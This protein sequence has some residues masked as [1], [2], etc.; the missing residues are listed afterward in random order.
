DSARVTIPPVTISYT[1]WNNS[2]KKNI[3]TN[4]ITVTVRTLPVNRQEDIRDVKEPVKLPLN[5]LLI[6]LI[7]LALFIIGIASYYLYT[8]YRKKKELKSAIIPEIIIPPH[9]RALSE[10]SELEKKK[11]WQN[12]FVKEYHSEVTEIVRQYFEGRFNFRALEMTSSEILAVLSYLEDGKKI[13]E[14]LEL[15]FSN[16]DLVKFAKYEPMPKV[17]EEMMQQA[18]EIVNDTIPAVNNSTESGES[19]VQ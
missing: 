3:R 8:Y 17:N 5:W 16:A 18:F 9:E 11:L 14:K 13:R 1:G 6:G 10:L 15:F 2:V 12:G 19:N 4:P 7:I